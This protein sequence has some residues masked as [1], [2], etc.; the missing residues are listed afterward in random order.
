MASNIRPL[1]A[2]VVLRRI[3][4]STSPG[5]IIVPE[6]AQD[7]ES[8]FWEVVAVGPGRLMQDGSRVACEVAVGDKVA[9]I[10]QAHLR[11][12]EIAVEM[13]LIESSGT[14]LAEKLLVIHE[15]AIV[16]VV[17]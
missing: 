15:D 12:G 14:R 1:A 13:G 10:P 5:G 2:Q 11:G 7:R 17:T 9:M 4:N 3:R 8:T 6:S 16:A